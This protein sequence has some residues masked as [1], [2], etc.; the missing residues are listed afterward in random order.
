MYT[1]AKEKKGKEKDSMLLLS[2]AALFQLLTVRRGLR[3]T[4]TVHY[5]CQSFSVVLK[6]VILKLDK[7]PPIFI[8][9]IKL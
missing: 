3:T 5:S 1:Y 2:L 9:N 6:N 8:F 4:N 7:H